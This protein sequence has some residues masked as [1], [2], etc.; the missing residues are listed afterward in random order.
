MLDLGGGRVVD[1]D[2]GWK[3]SRWKSRETG[4]RGCWVESVSF[5]KKEAKR[6]RTA[7]TKSMRQRRG[8]Q[9]K[10][11]LSRSKH[12]QAESND[13][14]DARAPNLFPNASLPGKRDSSIF[15]FAIL[16]ALLPSR[17]PP[18][19]P[20]S[21]SSSELASYYVFDR[22]DS[23]CQL[24]ARQIKAR[25]EA[26]RERTNVGSSSTLIFRRFW[27]LVHVRGGILIS[28]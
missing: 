24:L 18:F 28:K 2:I 9:P 14:L 7:T 13:L 10:A 22:D 12:I 6:E 19:S 3:G 27:R 16:P 21:N 17:L 4:T 11:D 20:I 15:S 5:W 25:N 23:E 26:E 1:G 8:D